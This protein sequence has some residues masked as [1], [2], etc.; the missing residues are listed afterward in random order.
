[1]QKSEVQQGLKVRVIDDYSLRGIIIATEH[2]NGPKWVVVEWDMDHR[3][4]PIEFQEL[5]IIPESD[6]SLEK[7]FEQLM[8]S[9]GEQIK[10]HV[11]AAQQAIQLAVNLADDHGIPFFTTV[12]EI[13]QP[14]V[15]YSFRDK[16]ADLDPHYVADLTEIGA[17]ELARSGGWNTSQVC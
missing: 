17:H 8:D 1:M 3:V 16:W 12:S 6:G 14:Y 5:S 4:E 15:P 10:A 11:R 2:R 7:E 9:V 13:G